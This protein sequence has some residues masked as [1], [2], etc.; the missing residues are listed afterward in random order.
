MKDSK[1]E[2]TAPVVFLL[3]FLFGQHFQIQFLGGVRH[4]H[5][6]T[7]YSK[8]KKVLVPV[9]SSRPRLRKQSA[10][11]PSLMWVSQ[12]LAESHRRNS[13]TK[14]V[15][16]KYFQEIMRFSHPKSANFPEAYRL[17]EFYNEVQT[18]AR[19]VVDCLE[20]TTPLSSPR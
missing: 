16:F 18:H 19:N 17:W 8:V 10:A 7:E 11:L 15:Y 3:K 1:P 14:L 6:I 4:Q 12:R 20:E 2:I 5:F 9:H 13:V